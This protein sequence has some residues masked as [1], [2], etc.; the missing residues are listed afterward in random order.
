[1]STAT[2]AEQQ[3]SVKPG[4]SRPRRFYLG[5]A[6]FMILMVF[7]G[8]WPSYFGPLLRGAA[9]RP[10]VIHLHGVVFMGWMALLLTQVALAARGR[11]K[12]HRKLGSFGIAYGFMVLLMGLVV[13]IAAPVLHLSAGEWPMDR[14]AGFLL[15]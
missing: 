15:I 8:F 10:L 13:A 2:V 3:S 6:A 7:V 11:T 1:M 14:A 5:M 4:I 9:A 12:A